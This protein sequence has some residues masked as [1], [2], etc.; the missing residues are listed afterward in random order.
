MEQQTSNQLFRPYV[1]VTLRDAL[2]AG[3]LRAGQVQTYQATILYT[4][5][6]GFTRLTASFAT[7][8]DGAEH[9]HNILNR[10]F[11]VMIATITA[12][13]GD[14]IQIAG[15]AFTAWWPGITDPAQAIQCGYA[16]HN[17]IATLNPIMTP[18]GPFTLELRVGI[19][20]G[21][22]YLTLVGTPNQGIHP[23]LIGSPVNAASLAEQQA[24][25]GE[26]Q[27]LLFNA[28]PAPSINYYPL[29]APTLRWEHFLP[30]SFAR[31]LQLNTLVTEYRRCVPVFAAFDLPENPVDLQTLVVQAQ[32]I[33]MRWGGWLNE[34]EI[35][36]KGTVMVCL[37]GAPISHGDDTG[38]AVGC[39]IEL[40]DRGV[41]RKA[42]I[43]VGTLFVGEVGSRLRR[44]YTAQ[45]EEMNL[46]AL[47]MDRAQ[48]GEII[49]SGRVRQ[50]VL[51]RY[52]TTLPQP[53]PIKGYSQP[54]PTAL[55]L[56]EQTIA[57]QHGFRAL[58]ASLAVYTELVGRE[59]ERQ[60]L[61]QLI[62]NA[63]HQGQVLLIEGEAGIGKS[64]LIH[65]LSVKWLEHGYHGFRG[66]CQSGMQEHLLYPW[67][68]ILSEL[69]GIDD[70]MPTYAKRERL[71]QI[72]SEVSTTLSHHIAALARLLNIDG[73]APA[74]GATDI[75]PLVIELLIGRLK[76][77]PLLIVI[78]DIH[79]ADPASMQLLNAIIDS[80]VP[81]LPLLIAV[82][83]RP[84]TEHVAPV[85]ARIRHQPFTTHHL[86][87]RLPVA[88]RLYLIRQLIGVK[89]ID[90]RLIQY[91]ERYAAGQP[92][93]IKEYV[94]VLLQKGLIIIEEDTARLR[95]PPPPLQL[96]SPAL[97]IVQARIDQMEE[98]IRLTLKVAAVIGRSFP[99]RLLQ[100]I[101]PAHLTDDELRQ[102]IAVLV[103]DQL[104]ELEMSD[105]EPIYRFV[106]GIAHE[107]A[108]N[109]LLFAQR[110]D[111]HQAVYA[112]YLTTYQNELTQMKAPLAVYDVMIHH[113]L[114]A[115]MQ[116]NAI[117]HCWQ[118]ALI[119]VQRS[120]FQTALHYI[121]KGIAP[122]DN[123]SRRTELLVLRIMLN[124]RIGDHLHQAE[125]FRLFKNLLPEQEQPVLHAITA[126]LYLH[127]L[128]VSGQFHLFH[129]Q[130]A[131]T[132][133]QI[134]QLSQ[135]DARSGRFLRACLCLI[136]AQYLAL[137]GQ[138]EQA[139]ATLRRVNRICKTVPSNT[140][141]QP[142]ITDLMTLGSLSAQS[143]ELQGWI[144]IETGDFRQ[145]KKCFQRAVQQARSVNDRIVENRAQIGLCHTMI[146][147]AQ[148][149]AVEHR[150]QRA[151]HIARSISD[152]YGQVLGLRTQAFLHLNRHNVNAA[153]RA[154]WQAIAIANSSRIGVL[155][156]VLLN[157][158]EK[159]ARAMH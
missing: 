73:F 58:Q 120:L 95:E 144:L 87:E 92:L 130:S 145:A 138:Y 53:M 72:A 68:A 31:R 115:E 71:Q 37:F 85:I 152:R 7:L 74:T 43:T 151:I 142:I 46:A 67:R 126:V 33:T 78:E 60:I 59:Q 24:S 114:C 83:Y 75:S 133:T 34:I 40:R 155:E 153:H 108:Y 90:P 119:C 109:S 105:P 81:Q 10:Y 9:L 79:W 123:S 28:Q 26:V 39:A 89:E 110:R 122:T 64:S 99:L 16:L 48:P 148:Y 125:D 38:R 84:L 129:T 29:E 27:L 21:S 36:N 66:D 94:R 111:L 93:F 101:H 146:M 35:G 20:V 22:V 15:D 54:I 17:A 139:M 140:P 134:D 50:D 88:E 65:H 2:D 8:P 158:L 51:S 131:S 124:D 77:E 5:L 52:H 143:Y 104:I 156:I 86:L 128:L 106:F 55:V 136:H 70:S 159:L 56:T 3:A 97:G 98:R 149:D 18:N 11:E 63:T 135:I 150:I 44:V 96:S 12:N 157:Q 132:Q 23:V 49:I 127:H 13:G 100:H 30:P 113:S 47:L 1:P 147:N 80:L 19:S 45:G 82:S 42:G 14:V 61:E 91:L 6:R 141:P 25:P 107:A 112:W 62:A 118:A 57:E 32:A 103:H 102:D 121:E 116:A 69:C 137:Q 154:I 4:D 41:I 117:E 76:H